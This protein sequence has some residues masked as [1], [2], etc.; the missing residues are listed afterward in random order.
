MN[1]KERAEEQEQAA[2][3]A[4]EENA[5]TLKEEDLIRRESAAAAAA[6]IVEKIA[7]KD[8]AA[9]LRAEKNVR[10]GGAGK[11]QK[12]SVAAGDASAKTGTSYV[13]VENKAEQVA[14]NI[15]HPL[16]LC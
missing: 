7:A 1:D 13:A 11:S 16:W 12:H 10:T 15:I 14:P 4:E 2:R 8:L 3:V 6:K 5:H 9:D